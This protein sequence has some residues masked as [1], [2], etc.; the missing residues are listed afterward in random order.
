MVSLALNWSPPDSTP[1]F[2]ESGVEGNKNQSTPTSSNLTSKATPSTSPDSKQPPSSALSS[3]SSSASSSAL[4]SNSNSGANTPSSTTSLSTTLSPTGLPPRNASTSPQP[5]SYAQA[6]EQSTSGRSNSIPSSQEQQRMFHQQQQQ[7]APGLP[8]RMGHFPAFAHQVSLQ[9][10][11]F[12]KGKGCLMKRSHVAKE[13]ET[14]ESRE[15]LVVETGLRWIILA[16]SDFLS[17]K[18][19]FL[20]KAWLP[21][22]RF[23]TQSKHVLSAASS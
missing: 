15:D 8:N 20:P 14:K 4:Q 6:A 9:Y 5:R 13:E 11:I 18:S 12:R 17:S 1:L 2:D 23:R 22:A 19:S 16:P 10:I 7:Q 21:T 3:A